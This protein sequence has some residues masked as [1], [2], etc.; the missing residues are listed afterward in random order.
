MNQSFPYRIRKKMQQ[1]L[2]VIVYAG[3]VIKTKA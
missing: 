1:Q 3:G 2:K